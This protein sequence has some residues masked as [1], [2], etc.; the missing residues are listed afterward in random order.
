MR[1]AG[2]GTSGNPGTSVPEPSTLLGL[3]TLALASGTL[4][5]RRRKE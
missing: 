4:L 1:E 2:S 3:G 5:R